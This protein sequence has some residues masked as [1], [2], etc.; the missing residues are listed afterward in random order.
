MFKNIELLL[1]KSSGK[2]TTTY[3]IYKGGNQDTSIIDIAK[4]KRTF[5]TEVRR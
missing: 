2:P 5:K 4:N 3:H 1:K